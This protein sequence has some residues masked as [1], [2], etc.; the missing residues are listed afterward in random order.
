MYSAL[1]HS[2]MREEPDRSLGL[3]GWPSKPLLSP[4]HTL[5]PTLAHPDRTVHFSE[6]HSLDG[7]NRSSLQHSCDTGVGTGAGSHLPLSWTGAHIRQCLEGIP[8]GRVKFLPRDFWDQMHYCCAWHGGLFPETAVWFFPK[9]SCARGQET[10]STSGLHTSLTL[11]RNCSLAAEPRL[12]DPILLRELR[13][14]TL[15]TSLGSSLSP[16]HS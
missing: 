12:S 7:R 11:S 4:C 6:A 3:S 1:L 10:M 9:E 5:T 13:R 2:A 14:A 8:E 16:T 15:L